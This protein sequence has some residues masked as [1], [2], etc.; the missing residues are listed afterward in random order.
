MADA[1]LMA[2]AALTQDAALTAAEGTPVAERMQAGPVMAEQLVAT[3]AAEHAERRR[4]GVAI[5]AAARLA[6]Q[7]AAVVVDS[8]AAAVAEPTAAVV[9]TGNPAVRAVYPGSSRW[10]ACFGKRAFCFSA[11]TIAFQKKA[12]A[13]W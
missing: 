5:A 8:T 4:Q 9:V 10:P 7:S 1:V 2:D 13:D 3:P 6:A 11:K 12:A